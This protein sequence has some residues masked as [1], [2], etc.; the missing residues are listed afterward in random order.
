[1]EKVMLPRKFGKH[2]HR[3]KLRR[4]QDHEVMLPG[5][6]VLYSK[7]H[8][9]ALEIWE[10]WTY[11]I[12]PTC[13]TH[14]GNVQMWHSEAVTSYEAI[15]VLTGSSVEGRGGRWH[16]G[17]DAKGGS[18]S[19][20]HACTGE[21]VM[22]LDVAEESTTILWI[23][24][25]AGIHFRH[26]PFGLELLVDGCCLPN[27][28]TWFSVGGPATM[29]LVLKPKTNE[30]TED[31]FAAVEMRD[32]GA[33]MWYLTQGQDP[34][35][36]LQDSIL[37]SAIETGSLALVQTLLE[38]QACPNF[39]PPHRNSPLQTAVSHNQDHVLS[40]L[41][42]CGADPNLVNANGDSPLHLAV[43]YADIP[44]S[45][46]L[47][48]A[49]AD[50]LLRNSDS[51]SAF[52]YAERGLLVLMCICHCDD[53]VMPV[54][55]IARHL[56]SIVQYCC[57]RSLWPVS[58]FFGQQQ[59]YWDA[60]GGGSEVV[61]DLRQRLRG[62]TLGG[63]ERVFE[64]VL[65]VMAC[66]GNE[67]CT[68]PVSEE[69]T[70]MSLKQRIALHL[71]HL[72]FAVKIL[73]EGQLVA[74][75]G[76]TWATLGSPRVLHIVLASR[77]IAH[78]NCLV[79]AI[80]DQE[81]DA[82][83]RILA[84]GQ[85]PDYPC[86][87]RWRAELPLHTAASRGFF[88]SVHLLLTGFADPN[89]AGN[90][91]R[92]AMHLA[93][94]AN[95]PMTVLV[96][97]EHGANVH[98][99]DVQGATALHFAAVQDSVPLVKQLLQAGA[100]PLI[101]DSF[102]DPPLSWWCGTDVKAMLMNSCWQ[103]LSFPE[104][105][106][107]N[108]RI[109]QRYMD[110]G[111]LPRVC[112]TLRDCQGGSATGK[113]KMCNNEQGES[114]NAEKGRAGHNRK[115]A[116]HLKMSRLEGKFQAPTTS[117]VPEGFKCLQDFG[118]QALLP[119]MLQGGYLQRSIMP[120][121]PT[122][123]PSKSPEVVDHLK[124]LHPHPRDK[125]LSFE[126][127]SHTYF[128]DGRKVSISTTGLIHRFSH[129]FDPTRALAQMQAGSQWPRPKYLRSSIPTSSLLRL[130]RLGY[131]N[132]LLSMLS[133][134]PRSDEAICN[135]VRQCVA[136]HPEDREV[137]LSLAKSDSE[138][139]QQWANAG[140][141]GA[142][143][144]TWMHTTF[145]CLLNGGF[146]TSCDQELTLCLSFL[147]AVSNLGATIFRTEWMIYA[148]AEDLAGSIDLVL[149]LLGS[150]KLI[151]VDWKRTQ[152]IRS[153]GISYG[154]NMLGCL[155]EIPDC[156][157]WHYRLQLNVY[158]HILG[159]YYGEE[160]S[161]MF[162]VG[163]HPDN[164]QSPFVES[165]PM[166]SEE[167]MALMQTL[168][169]HDRTALHQDC[170]GGG[171]SQDFAAAWLGH[172]FLCWPL[173]SDEDGVRLLR[174]FQKAVG[175]VWPALSAH[176]HLFWILP[177]PLSKRLDHA[178]F[179]L[180]VTA[181][182]FFMQLLQEKQFK[183]LELAL[184]VFFWPEIKSRFFIVDMIFVSGCFEQV[185]DCARH[186]AETIHFLHG[187]WLVSCSADAWRQQ[188]TQRWRSLEVLQSL[189]K[190]L[191]FQ[192]DVRRV[193]FPPAKTCSCSAGLIL[194]QNFSF[195][196][197]ALW[198]SGY[199]N[200]VKAVFVE[201]STVLASHNQLCNLLLASSRLYSAKFFLLL[202]QD[203]EFDFLELA[204]YIF[205]WPEIDQQP[206]LADCLFAATTSE[207][208]CR[209]CR[210]L[211]NVIH[212]LHCASCLDTSSWEEPELSRREQSFSLVKS[213]FQ[214]ETLRASLLRPPDKSCLQK[215]DANEGLDVCGGASQE[216]MS[217]DDR[218]AA[219]QSEMDPEAAEFLRRMDA[220]VAAEMREMEAER[221]A[222][223]AEGSTI[224]PPATYQEEAAPP[225]IEATPAKEEHADDEEDPVL[226]EETS[227]STWNILK[228]RR[229]LPGALTSHEDFANLF[230]S[231]ADANEDFQIQPGEPIDNPD[232]ILYV[233]QKRQQ[234]IERQ[235]PRFSKH[236]VRM[237]TA[238]QA[239]FCMRVADMSLREHALMLWII[240][241]L[242]FLRFH[243]GDCYMLH[244]CGAFQRYKGVPPDT[245]RISDFLLQLEGLFRRLP[246]D[247]PRDPQQL[248]QAI[249][250]EWRG[251]GENDESL[252]RKCI[253]AAVSNVGESLLKQRGGED[254][255]DLDA[256]VHNWRFHAART[257]L[258]LKVRLA[259]ELT[260]EKLL[261]YMVEWCETSKQAAPACCFED[262]C[263]Q[264]CENGVARQA[265]SEAKIQH[266]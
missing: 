25:Q 128:W 236:I 252:S 64:P 74:A 34:N 91:G 43:M 207:L 174:D 242:D 9:V 46:S 224:E 28:V 211:A 206:Y 235:Y 119:I 73:L 227:E 49:G 117:G 137:L 52:F 179:L 83:I 180:R 86:V 47:L 44:M 136:Q 114:S 264:Y 100:D 103:R 146:V 106:R 184:Y 187:C 188:V 123:W 266:N 115:V 122:T 60:L 240:E 55:L 6:Y 92:T 125:L 258:Q 111:Q 156:T 45:C 216:G 204:L 198:A 144:G 10:D 197:D 199:S 251:A 186:M 143:Q 181:S 118:L 239:I 27:H 39:A 175:P 42:D 99:P 165:V 218:V 20:A 2:M 150:S 19:I 126:A 101:A 129:G 254:A 201:C 96:L 132:E 69:C 256:D 50:P 23:K 159:K 109:L 208:R 249:D 200:E 170:Q 76:D 261:H 22:S 213:L 230:Q 191:V 116:L 18:V 131:T 246:E 228:K 57:C 140:A 48:W 257:V 243:D 130:E 185:E 221:E 77:T 193:L 154:K 35:C 219:E 215:V 262:C 147:R 145:E 5:K 166:M 253:K 142:S 196:M 107:L 134:S 29:L 93:A 158:R 70:V 172:L 238:A 38:G 121:K 231:L 212:I 248:L 7:S 72:P 33:V 263:I 245:S 176:P 152:D 178:S 82:V 205:H 66:T 68:L 233:V 12:R 67:I 241:G 220:E 202:L 135:F 214:S 59:K 78:A 62:D 133:S 141:E 104:L 113:R 24:Q 15:F 124:L 138:I 210:H 244:P 40:A 75:V 95:S 79:K 149:K 209:R 37:C 255:P 11:I 32:V 232:T 189:S 54:D 36:T 17:M 167:V 234:D 222:R 58:K 81:H 110:C 192:S 164:G 94:L 155:K 108:V 90:D 41:L 56:P 151:L 173:D 177:N 71:K 168:E 162:I 102:H 16:E 120:V 4:V 226:G 51:Q 217:F 14:I 127:S 53:R 65:V 3:K 250:H 31:I 171:C 157:L 84:D 63:G 26:P 203:Q 112:R 161:M 89:I 260:E 225:P 160:V 148:E 8:F 163:C 61:W 105:L 21:E 247:V 153:K 229:L 223:R 98:A 182:S 85:E 13:R 87:R 30:W 88:Y 97:A 195:D 80:H 139:R 183:F 190:A 237:A 194:Q 1:M 259:R 169:W 265:R